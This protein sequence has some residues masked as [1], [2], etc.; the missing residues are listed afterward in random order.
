MDKGQL[1][2]LKHC[3]VIK[4][5]PYHCL[6]CLKRDSAWKSNAVDM[7]AK[8]RRLSVMRDRAAHR[9]CDSYGGGP[10]KNAVLHKGLFCG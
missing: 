1:R 8:R 7:I 2:G 10:P 4:Q 5:L 3:R 9:P 6:Q